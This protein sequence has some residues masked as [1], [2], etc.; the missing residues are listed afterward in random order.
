MPGYKTHIT[1]SSAAGLGLGFV[2]YTFYDVSLPQAVFGGVL[3][4]LGG[5]LPDID[6]DTSKAFQRCITTISGTCALLLASR[7]RDFA[8]EPE[9]VVAACAAFYFFIVYVVGGL[10]KKITVHRGMC[11]SIP[12]AVIA[13]ELIFILSSGSTQLRLFKSASIFIGVIIHLSL[14]EAN[15][16]TVSSSSRRSY[17]YEDDYSSSYRY[18]GR[19]STTRQRRR[20]SRLRVPNVRVPRVRVKNSFGTALKLIDYKHMGTTIVVYVVAAFLGRC[21]MGVQDFL[22]SMGDV[23]QTEIQGTLAIERVRRIY[24]E[25]FELSVV[26]WVAENDLVLSP[27]QADNSKWKELEQMLAIGEDAAILKEEKAK[28]RLLPRSKDKSKLE[29]TE[30]VVSLLDVVNWNS[31]N[32]PDSPPIN[33]Q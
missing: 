17:D 21:A 24:P 9:G 26:R 18:G 20:N 14:D 2:A 13:G 23:D 27:G 11:H 33:N 1:W 4:S 28:N 8:L 10:V 32:K 19:S 25:Q 22:A 15:S 31:A 5:V 29:E 12:F 3:C 16:F 7:L 30:D 6:S